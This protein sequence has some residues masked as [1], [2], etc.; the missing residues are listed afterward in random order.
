MESTAESRPNLESISVI[1]ASIVVIWA[2]IVVVKC[3]V[4]ANQHNTN[5][6]LQEMM[7]FAQGQGLQ[8][9]IL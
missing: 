1:W 2:S 3:T 8:E 7:S 4:R 6:F 9:R 5:T